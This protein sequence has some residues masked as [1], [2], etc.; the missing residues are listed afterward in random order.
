MEPLTVFP[1]SVRQLVVSPSYRRHSAQIQRKSSWNDAAIT[2]TK[3]SRDDSATDSFDS[4]P[5]HS[6]ASDTGEDWNTVDNIASLGL[7][8]QPESTHGTPKQ[9]ERF[10]IEEVDDS[11]D[12][13][14]QR[15]EDEKPF[16]KWMH[17][18]QKRGASRRR[19]IS[20]TSEA[21]RMQN[22]LFDSPATRRASHKKSSSQSSSGFVT[23]VRSASMSFR[24]TF[25]LKSR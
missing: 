21:E 19:T 16:S 23:A 22:E 1:S 11:R 24:P 20:G 10:T 25:A 7:S 3:R 5:L 9:F 18:L 17:S 14:Y 6:P 12:L 4:V 2:P 15:L 13:S 8:L